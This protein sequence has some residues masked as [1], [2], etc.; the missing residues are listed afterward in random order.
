MIFGI[1]LVVVGLI[2]ILQNMGYIS[3]SSWGIIWP[4]LLIIVGISMI[5]KKS[6]H[7]MCGCGCEEKKDK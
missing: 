2:F 7:C 3:A 4:A 6:G 5:C 1:A